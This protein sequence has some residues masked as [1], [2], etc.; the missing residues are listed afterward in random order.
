MDTENNY[1]SYA[2]SALGASS[3]SEFSWIRWRDERFGKTVAVIIG[4]EVGDPMAESNL[5]VA[6]EILKDWIGDVDEADVFEATVGRSGRTWLRTLAVKVYDDNGD[7]TPAWIRAVDGIMAP[8]EN[9]PIL[10]EDD[11][12]EREW[13]MN[14][15]SLKFD[16]GDAVDLVVDAIITSSGLPLEEVIG[17]HDAV[18]QSV[19][20]HLASGQWEKEIVLDG[21]RHYI[22]QRVNDME[23]PTLAAL[24]K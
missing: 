5:Q 12:Y 17:D 13:Q 21:L 7:F 9:Y 8:L 3:P 19:E 6:S 18:V 11:Y 23:I 24:I 16:Y 15:E 10:D 20:N 1:Q 2:D 4:G 14:Y 22:E